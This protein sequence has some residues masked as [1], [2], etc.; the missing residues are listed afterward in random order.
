MKGRR[1]IV[2]VIGPISYNEIR[3]A[4]ELTASLHRDVLVGGTSVQCPD[5]FITSLKGL[6]G[7][8]L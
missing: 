2:F 7:P 1:L 5:E 3:A 6:T 4:H 8:R